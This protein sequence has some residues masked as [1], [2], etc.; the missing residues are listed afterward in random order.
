MASNVRLG[1]QGEQAA[2][3]YLRSQGYVVLEQNYRCPLG[4][5]DIVAQKGDV[6]AFVEVKTR[7]SLHYGRPCEAVNYHK[8]RHII[9]TAGWYIGSHAASG[10]RYRFDVV[11]VLA[12]TGSEMRINHIEN[13]FEAS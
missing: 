13:A 9:N 11:E 2:A 5:L 8:K 4:E 6:V 12:V 10:V 7:R 1:R 3:D